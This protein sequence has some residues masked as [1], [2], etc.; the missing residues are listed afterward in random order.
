MF[1][2]CVL[3][4]KN[5]AT[6]IRAKILMIHTRLHTRPAPRLRTTTQF[7]DSR[8][9]II[10]QITWWV[11]PPQWRN[12]FLTKGIARNLTQMYYL[13]TY[14]PKNAL[15]CPCF[16]STLQNSLRPNLN[17]SYSTRYSSIRTIDL[18]TDT[19]AMSTF[20]LSFRALFWTFFLKVFLE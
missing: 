14:V 1:L 6:S 13:F 15:Q 18:S 8:T 9:K 11:F 10:S 17:T 12:N 20:R 5:S 19:A 4:L 2:Y 3:H 7:Q 16:D